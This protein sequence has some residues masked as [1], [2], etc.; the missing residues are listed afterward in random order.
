MEQYYTAILK[1]S[2]GKFYAYLPEALKLIEH[3]WFFNGSMNAI[4]KKLLNN[5]HNV[6]WVG[7]YANS[8][9]SNEFVD[10]EQK[11]SGVRIKPNNKINFMNHLL[12]N[13]TKEEFID[14]T[15]Y[16]NNAIRHYAKQ[17]RNEDWVIHP[18]SL[19][20]AMGNGLGGGDYYGSKAI[21]QHI[22]G[23]WAGDL[24][25]VKCYDK[26]YKWNTISKEYQYKN[27]TNLNMLVFDVG[28]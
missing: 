24:I 4:C 8:Q 18:L 13:H 3:S 2:N 17:D 9:Y 19:L 23:T 1:D 6:A 21:N 25:E 12:I 26:D 11:T 27:Y 20:T 28:Y 15:E 10:Y 14:L 7:D 5:P 16:Y 22:V